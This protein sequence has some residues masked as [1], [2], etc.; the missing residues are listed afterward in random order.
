MTTLPPPEPRSF[1]EEVQAAT[2]GDSRLLM[3]I[4][5]GTCGGSCPSAKDMD[6]SPRHIFALIRAE[7]REE[8]FTSNTPWY[9]VSCYYCMARCPQDVH[10]TDIMYTLK[11]M[12]IDSEFEE[13]KN[14]SDLA[15]AFA[16]NVDT[17]G[18]SFEF[19]LATR[20]YLRHQ[21]S[22]LLKKAQMGIGMLMKGRLE[23]TPDKIEG[24]DQLKTILKKAKELEAE[25]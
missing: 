6:H 5:C 10:I 23:L 1:L 22:T 21:T 19:G 16:H 14:G 15:H 17:Y 11:N 4:Q 9:C 24:M 12:S 8:V 7:M 25:R 3:C 13:A 2:P 20:H 18:R